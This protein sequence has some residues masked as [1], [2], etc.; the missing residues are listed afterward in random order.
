MEESVFLAM[1]AVAAAGSWGIRA[2]CRSG[3]MSMVPKPR[4]SKNAVI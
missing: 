2:M 1:V 3:K 4:H